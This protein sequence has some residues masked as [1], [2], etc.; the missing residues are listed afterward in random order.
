[1]N[2]GILGGGQLARMMAQAGRSLGLNF[3][4]LCPNA[5]PC[6]ASFGKHLCSPY[7]DEQAQK[8]L[9]EWAEVVT[10]EF[11]NVSLSALESLQ[12][13]VTLYPSSSALA[14]ARDRL[15]EKARF[16][17]LG[18]PTATFA[19]VET[20]SGLTQALQGIG[21]PA[22]LKNRTQ[23]YDGKG[24]AMLS[25]EA[26]LASAWEQ[27]G[28][29]PC[30]VE[31]KVAFKREISVIAA[32]DQNG[33]MVFYPISENHHRDGILRLSITR[34][35]DPLQTQANSMIK[36]IMEDLEYVGL[37]AL[38]LFQVDDQLFANEFAP[39]VHNSGHWTTEASQT[40]QFENH[41]RAICGLPLGETASAGPA[42]MV[43]LIGRLPE[44]EKI[45]EV[46]GAT[47]HFYGKAERPGRKVGHVTLTS[48]DCTTEE[49]AQSLT[50]LLQMAGE[51]ELADSS[52]SLVLANQT[53]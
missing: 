51:L 23:G 44:E 37:M 25:E 50:T 40:S 20:L 2:I 27:L 34:L 29:S 6:A 18:I 52:Q 13:Q 45:L 32:R 21:L 48:E 16:G 28:K 33:E 49:F 19:P 12:Q 15:I 46:P 43:N 10:Y 35:N 47:P 9:A 4:F 5:N 41:L 24:Q 1:M 31:S 22:I 7:D 14:V 17:S 30:I 38:E 42:A 36:K 26:D 53:V 39:R 11:E 8:Q 3:M